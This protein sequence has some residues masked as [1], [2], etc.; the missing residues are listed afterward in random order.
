MQVPIRNEIPAVSGFIENEGVI[1]FEAAHYT[2]KID[3]KEIHWTVVPNLGRTNSS[4]IIEPVTAE[5]QSI[6]E[7]SPRVEYEFTSFSS[8]DFK[9]E[10]YLS[11][12]QDFK[13]QGGLKYAIAIDNEKPQIINM[14]EG[15]TVPDYKYAGWW[16]KSVGD[17]IKIKVSSH[18]VELPGKH[19]LKIWAIDP[20]I[21]FQKFV[22]D[23]GGLRPSYLGPVESEKNRFRHNLLLI[24]PKAE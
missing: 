1:A 23:T 13:N 19:V 5:S 24:V 3:K 17:H 7:N 12:T 11:P 14:N 16:T 10:A 21:V 4:L 15:E 9:V 8:G 20:G 22:I 2:R 6:L 18:D